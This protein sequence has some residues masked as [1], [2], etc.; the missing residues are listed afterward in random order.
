MGPEVRDLFNNRW[1]SALLRGVYGSGLKTGVFEWHGRGVIPQFRRCAEQVVLCDNRRGVY[2]GDVCGSTLAD[3]GCLTEAERGSRRG[4]AAIAP[5]LLATVALRGPGGGGGGS[6]QL[7][8]VG[9]SS[10]ELMVRKSF[11]NPS[12]AAVVPCAHVMGASRWVKSVATC[13]IRGQAS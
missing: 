3:C 9:I 13:L 10:C 11:L 2:R 5:G 1:A 8:R 4:L 7:C 12:L 6:G